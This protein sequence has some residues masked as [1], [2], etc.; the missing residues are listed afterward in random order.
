MHIS[1]SRHG[2]PPSLTSWHDD[3]EPG[4]DRRMQRAGSVR[5]HR[6]RAAVPRRGVELR[7][8]VDEVEWEPANSGVG[9]ADQHQDVA[10]L[11]EVGGHAVVGV[12]HVGDR[13]D[14]ERGWHGVPFA[15]GA[16]VLVVERVLARHEGR[17]VHA[18]AASQHPS[19]AATSSPSVDG[20]RGSPHEKLSSSAIRSG[21]APTATT[22]RIASSTTANA[23]A[24]GSCRPYH[25]LTPMPIAMPVR[26][27]RARRAPRRRRDRRRRRRRAG[28]RRSTRGSRG[29]SGG[30]SPP[31]TRCSGGR[32][33]RAASLRDRSTVRPD[34]SL[35]FGSGSS[36][37]CAAAGVRRAGTRCRCRRRRCPAAHD[38]LAVDR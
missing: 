3:D 21:S 9:L 17:V 37:A 33:A 13:R 14:H 36:A 28:G 7:C 8:A 38:Q 34:G 11:G 25:G 23:I 6:D 20:R 30:S 31:W 29:R 2:E 22:L 12:G 19:T 16:D 27:G 4:A 26:R 35:R 24:S 15:V 1:A 18:G 10:G 5:A 32:A